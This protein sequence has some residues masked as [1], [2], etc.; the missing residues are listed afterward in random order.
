[1][2]VERKVGHFGFPSDMGWIRD[3]CNSTQIKGRKNT[4]NNLESKQ[5]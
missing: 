4:R 2:R 1:V 3:Q 5:Q